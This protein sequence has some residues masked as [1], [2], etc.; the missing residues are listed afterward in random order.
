MSGERR[1]E[2]DGVEKDREG[3]LRE[4]SRRMASR[5]ANK[6][7]FEKTCARGR[8]VPGQEVKRERDLP[9]RRRVSPQE[10]TNWRMT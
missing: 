5:R 1:G 4:V 9:E 10:E 8:C 2:K 7:D 6:Y 3:W